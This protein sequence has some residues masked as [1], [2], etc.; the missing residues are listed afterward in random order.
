MSSI[1]ENLDKKRSDYWSLDFEQ[2]R[3]YQCIPTT[4]GNFKCI[5]MYY[6]DSYLENSRLLFVN[7][8]NP[9]IF[10]KYVLQYQLTP[11]VSINKK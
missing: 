3:Y 1:S 2:Y 11:S 6:Q 8:K 9:Q 5:Q 10:D 4:F 7:K